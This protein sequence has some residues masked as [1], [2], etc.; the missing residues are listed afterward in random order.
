MPQR[1]LLCPPQRRAAHSHRRRGK[2]LAAVEVHQRRSRRP[3]R[4]YQGGPGAAATRPQQQLQ[5]AGSHPR[6]GLPIPYGQR[7][8]SK[9]LRGQ[10]LAAVEEHQRRSRR[11]RR[12]YQ[13]GPGAT[14]TRPHEQLQPGRSHPHRGLLQ[15]HRQRE[16]Q[17]AA[18][19]E[20]SGWSR[21]PRRLYQ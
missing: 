3:R 13:G 11:P 18:V 2:P 20:G 16:L 4:L 14:A 21:R 15:Q 12:L 5:P 17:V 19:E 1:K 9:Q 8:P 6:G 7:G 10:P